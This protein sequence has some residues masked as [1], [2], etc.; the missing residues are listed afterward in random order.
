[1][2]KEASE[3]IWL[4]Q[5]YKY[6]KQVHPGTDESEEEAGVEGDMEAGDCMFEKVGSAGNGM[7][8]ASVTVEKSGHGLGDGGTGRLEL[9]K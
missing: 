4:R 3:E 1:M 9:S 6:D 5:R 7:A 8:V 2:G